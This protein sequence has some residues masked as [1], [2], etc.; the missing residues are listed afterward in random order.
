MLLKTSIKQQFLEYRPIKYIFSRRNILSLALQSCW[1]LVTQKKQMNFSLLYHSY[2]FS[3]YNMSFYFL[4]SERPLPLRK[5][6]L[7]VCTILNKMTLRYRDIYILNFQLFNSVQV[8]NLSIKVLFWNSSH[9]VSLNQK[10]NVNF[11]TSKF[12][13]D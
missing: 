12:H 2:K 8:M 9:L 13:K 3:L 4:S 6:G 7:P 1:Y 5:L 10:Q 11:A